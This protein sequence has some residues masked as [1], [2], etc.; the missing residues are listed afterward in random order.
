MVKGLT[1]AAVLRVLTGVTAAA[2]VLMLAGAPATVRAEVA[3]ADPIDAAMRTCLAR[4]DMSSTAG[5]LQCM[6]TARLAWQVSSDQSF[7]KLLA[8]A[9]P[10]QRKR[11]Q[12]S[13]QAWKA[14][15]DAETQAL[16]AVTATTHGTRYQLSEGDL[17]L[18]PVRD[19]ALALRSAVAKTGGPD[20]PPPLRACSADPQCVHASADVTQY[21]RRLVNKM[22]Q[23]AWP[24]LWRAQQTWL[25]YRDA[26]APLGDAR[27]RIDLIGARVATLKKLAETAGND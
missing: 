10:A 20:A 16:A 11:W 17:R 19:R 8:K 3:A 1:A 23:R 24:V 22:P 4:A 5:Q 15:R 25:A 7:Q 26:T 6:D 9:P 12:A 21:Y 2:A 18:Q 14:W 13:E 27:A